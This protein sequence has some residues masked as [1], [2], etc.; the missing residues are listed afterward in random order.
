M[1]G[2]AAKT[3]RKSLLGVVVGF[4]VGVEIP[5]ID[6]H[7]GCG[8]CSRQCNG[9]IVRQKDLLSFL[10][11]SGAQFDFVQLVHQHDGND[12][13]YN[14][15]DQGDRATKRNAYFARH[16]CVVGE[17]RGKEICLIE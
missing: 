15:R 16:V 11:E 1:S 13:G 17:K 6:L 5:S 4:V 9:L 10:P 14:D 8:N 2:E 7:F 3:D 12:D